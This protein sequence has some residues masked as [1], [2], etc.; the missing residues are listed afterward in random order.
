VCRAGKPD[1]RRGFTL[2]ELLVVI[3]IIAI[4]IGLLLPAVQKVRESAARIQCTNNLKQLGIA[5]HNAHD[6]YLAM[7]PLGANFDPVNYAGSSQNAENPVATGP[8]K[9]IYGAT[10]MTFLL[11]F[12][13]QTALWAQFMAAQPTGYPGPGGSAGPVGVAEVKPMKQFICPAEPHP[14]SSGGFGMS[15]AIPSLA[16]GDYAGNFFVFGNMNAPC[17]YTP[18]NGGFWSTNIE[19]SAHLSSSF[20]DGTA[21]TIMLAE[22]WGSTCGGNGLLWGDANG[23][24]RPSF[25]DSPYSS[26]VNTTCPLFQTYQQARASCNPTLANALH[27]AGIMVCLADGSVRLV[28]NSVS[29]NT[30]NLACNPADGQTLPADW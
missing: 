22:R 30:W 2:I 4:L 14:G 10:L 28:N 15:T 6:T 9:G 11:P 3:A 12:V 8:Y 23:T 13:E 20:P 21:N 5:C 27:S 19:G 25:C 29:A 7:P 26:T 24:W 1:L 18:A 16:F 17:I